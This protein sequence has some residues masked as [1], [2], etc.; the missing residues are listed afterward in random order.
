MGWSIFNAASIGSVIFRSLR[1]CIFWVSPGWCSW[2]GGSEETQLENEWLKTSKKRN[3]DEWKPNNF[4]IICN[5]KLFLEW[6]VC[7]MWL[8]PNLWCWRLIGAYLGCC[9]RQKVSVRQMLF[10]AV[11][12][13]MIYCLDNNN[14]SFG[15]SMK[16]SHL[17]VLEDVTLSNKAISF[18]NVSCC[19]CRLFFQF[20]IGHVA[21]R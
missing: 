18:V 2:W 19:P 3:I 12:V 6:F 20:P 4:E 1:R 17:S 8:T 11:T 21:G 13:S 14:N 7:R 10:Q 15:S 16:Q 5:L 9:E